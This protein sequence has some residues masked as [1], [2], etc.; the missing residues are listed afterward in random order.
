[1]SYDNIL[2]EQEGGVG[3]VTLNRPNQL[4]AL[5]YKTFEELL[6]CFEDINRNETVR[7]VVLTGAGRAFSAGDDLKGMPPATHRHNENPA[8]VISIRHRQ[9][10]F[11]KM[12][13]YF[14][15]PT[16]AMINGHA[17]GAGSDIALGCDFRFAAEDAI[18]GDIRA[19]RAINLSTGA[20]WLLPRIVGLSKALEI[21]YTGKTFDGKEAERIGMVNRAVPRDQ[22]REVTLE[23]ARE[24][25]AGPTKALA[26]IKK[27]I[28]FDL[29]HNL[30][31]SLD[32]A[33][34]WQL[35][36]PVEDYVEGK[37]AFVEKRPFT[38]TG[39]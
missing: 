27:Q 4:N 23:F 26:Q 37:A 25:A 13:V 16:I 22:L 21:L 33:A 19:K 12:L 1:M 5:N 2:F 15:K 3:I 9:H 38:F 35:I 7:C 39:R 29:T 36:D 34:L 28:L 32:H 31:E 30:E 14:A 18:L 10:A 20:T 17:H 8:T 6:D 11:L 24:L